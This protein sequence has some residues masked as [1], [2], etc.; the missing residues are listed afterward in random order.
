MQ[1]T[2]SQKELSLACKSLSKT[3]SR[4]PHLP[5]LSGIFIKT[6]SS[7]LELTS[8]DLISG[9]KVSLPAQITQA[10][11]TV[12]NG[13]IFLETIAFFDQ[14]DTSF[15]LKEKELLLTN[16]K[17]KVSIPLLNQ[18]YPDFSLIKNQTIQE[19]TLD[20]WTQVVKK[21][22]FAAS[23]DQTRP[24]LTGILLR[25]EGECLQI[26]CT[27]GFRL[28]VLDQKM[29]TNFFH[30]QSLLLSAKAIGDL[31]SLL[32]I[33]NQD[34][35]NFSYDEINSQVF[36]FT[37]CFVYFT[38]LINSNYPPFEKIIPLEFATQITLDVHDF[39]KNLNKAAVFSRT[40][41]NIVKLK[42]SST[43][44]DFLANSL[45]DGSFESSQEVFNFQGD[46]L[47]I[48]FNIRYLLDFLNLAQG[49]TVALGLNGFD[50][51]ALLKIP[52]QETWQYVVMPFKP[53][54]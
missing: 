29:P 24:A 52:D 36:F 21:V 10:G 34:K 38:K 16:G 53:K 18:E 27:D 35:V 28:A 48:A 54:G 33:Y 25:G 37:D 44:V 32:Q 42:I 3:L 46:D 26:I 31:T 19:T 43:S 41:N 8:T 23:A 22:S 50:R 11:E 12:V 20:F 45:G 40:S 39:I 13:K 2:V 17:D 7:A 6:T 1:F 15:Q 47:Q 5:I 49:D 14:E 9:I 30:G 51:P 4:K